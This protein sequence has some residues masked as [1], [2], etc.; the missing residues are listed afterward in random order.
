MVTGEAVA[1]AIHVADVVAWLVELAQR[2]GQAGLNADEGL[3]FGERDAVVRG[4]QVCWMADCGSI[5]AAAAA[6]ANLIVAHEDLFYPYD[7]LVKGGPADFL[8]WRTNARRATLLGRHGVA[9]MRAH[10]TVDRSH[11]YDAFVEELALPLAGEPATDGSPYG[12]VYPIE[13]TTV[14]KLATHVKQ[15]LGMAA[16]RVAGDANAVVRRVGLPW[17]GMALFVNVGY[18][19]RLVALGADVLIAGESDN[20]GMRFALDARI[21]MIETSHEVSENPG[22]LR[23]AAQLGEAFPQVPVGSYENGICWRTL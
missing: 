12:R 19:Q 5:N 23:F 10:G 18:V 1:G 22:L 16:V 3:R 14:G 13:P 20:Y 6:G 11:I 9:V 2:N 8:T 17:G 21:P 7:V 15:R 4:I